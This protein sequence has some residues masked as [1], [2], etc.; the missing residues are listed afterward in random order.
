LV[1]R[2][3]R[4]FRIGLI[5]HRLELTAKAVRI[6]IFGIHVL[7]DG[8][9]GSRFPDDFQQRPGR[10]EQRNGQEQSQEVDPPEKD[11]PSTLSN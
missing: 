2:S 8:G 5:H 4:F 6:G 11:P 7:L 3:F 1:Q 10:L 9:S